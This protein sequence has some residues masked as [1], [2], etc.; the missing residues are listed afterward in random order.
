MN[1]FHHLH[2]HGMKTNLKNKNGTSA[3]I[4]NQNPINTNHENRTPTLNCLSTKK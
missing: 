1:Y 2:E 4:T 3:S